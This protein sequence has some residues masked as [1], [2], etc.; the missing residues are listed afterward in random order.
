MPGIIRIS[1]LNSNVL[2]GSASPYARFSMTAT[3]FDKNAPSYVTDAINCSIERVKSG[4]VEVTLDTE[5]TNPVLVVYSS[6]VSGANS[7]MSD[8]SIDDP[9]WEDRHCVGGQPAPDWTYNSSTGVFSISTY[10]FGSRIP[11]GDGEGNFPYDWRN[12]FR[13]LANGTTGV[14]YP[15]PFHLHG[16]IF[17]A[18]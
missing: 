4:I 18:P 12:L 5:I 3:Q 16:I 7:N 8:M 1:T 17:K 2:A 15:N 11:P 14:E 13:E 6:P 10:I 9:G